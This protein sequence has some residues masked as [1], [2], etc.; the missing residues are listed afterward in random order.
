MVGITARMYLSYMLDRY[1]LKKAG[2]KLIFERIQSGS[3][4]EPPAV[5]RKS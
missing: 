2:G 5:S 4:E 1:W 3:R